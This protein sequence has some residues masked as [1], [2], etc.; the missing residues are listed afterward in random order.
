[1]DQGRDKI[2][3]RGNRYGSIYVGSDKRR[4]VCGEVLTVEEL[5]SNVREGIR[6]GCYVFYL[7]E[8]YRIDA[9]FRGN[10]AKFVNHMW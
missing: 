7:T 1:V 3:D 9:E 4:A 5:D 8:K 10:L 6:S 2:N